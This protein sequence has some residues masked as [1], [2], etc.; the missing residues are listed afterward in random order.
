MNEKKSKCK[1]LIEDLEIE[2]IK[3]NNVTLN[4]LSGQDLPTLL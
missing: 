2:E 4:G 3:W 1:K